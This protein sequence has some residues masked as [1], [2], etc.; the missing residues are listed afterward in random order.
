MYDEIG[1]K[2]KI[3]GKAV[4]ILG[5]VAS[6]IMGFVIMGSSSSMVGTGFLILM[7]GSLLSWVSSLLIYGFGELIDHADT[8]AYNTR[9]VDRKPQYLSGMRNERLERLRADGLISEEEYQ[10][11][12]LK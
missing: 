6:V 1:S 2:I 7:V 3:V 12:L 9:N 8:I 4:C 10:Q 5:C 11:A